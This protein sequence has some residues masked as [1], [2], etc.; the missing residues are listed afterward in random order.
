MTERKIPREKPKP[1]EDLSDERRLEIEVIFAF[2]ENLTDS[3][4]PT[5]E[6]Q[7]I[8]SSSAITLDQKYGHESI[9]KDEKDS[10]VRYHRSRR[11]EIHWALSA[12]ENHPNYKK[13]KPYID[14][15]L[16]E[17]GFNPDALSIAELM[18]LIKIDRGKFISLKDLLDRR[19]IK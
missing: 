9:S 18:A 8:H 4:Y 12:G 14:H 10:I 3:L 7:A 15:V 5:L 17:Q 16:S 2:N 11:T 13:T 6:E 19:K 1:G